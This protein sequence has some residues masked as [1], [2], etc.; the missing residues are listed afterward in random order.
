MSHKA[1]CIFHGVFF[2]QMAHARRSLTPPSLTPPSY[3]RKM[4]VTPGIPLP[5][6]SRL[7]EQCLKGGSTSTYYTDSEDE[8]SHTPTKCRTRSDTSLRYVKSVNIL[9]LTWLSVTSEFCCHSRFLQ[10][11]T[12]GIIGIISIVSVMS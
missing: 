7:H 5:T 1:K 2:T 8:G 12:N 11:H 6:W 4:M 9:S 3:R 10:T